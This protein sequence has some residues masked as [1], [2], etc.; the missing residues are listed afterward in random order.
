[1][2][3]SIYLF[4]NMASLTEQR[5]LKTDSCQGNV[6]AL[7]PSLKTLFGTFKKLLLGQ[8]LHH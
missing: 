4:I 1:M 2:Y 7:H 6:I 3:F 5:N 8:Q